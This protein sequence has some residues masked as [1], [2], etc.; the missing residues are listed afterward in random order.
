VVGHFSTYAV[1]LAG[2]PGDSDF[3]GDIDLLDFA[4]LGACLAGPHGGLPAANCARLDLHP[5]ADVDLEDFASFQR[6]FTSE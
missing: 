4:R 2:A 1:V 5:D 3:D 6:I